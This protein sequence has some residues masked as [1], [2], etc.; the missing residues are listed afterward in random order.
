MVDETKIQIIPL[1]SQSTGDMIQ[2]I[3]RNDVPEGEQRVVVS[4]AKGQ[5]GHTIRDCD[6]SV[7][8]GLN[9]VFILNKKT[10]LPELVD[11]PLSRWD[12]IQRVGRVARDNERGIHL[13]LQPKDFRDVKSFVKECLDPGIRTEFIGRW[14]MKTLEKGENPYTTP[15][16]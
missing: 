16:P 6:V 3:C 7:D 5:V 13:L 12:L 10:N 8:S 15:Y 9:R 4:T 11:L 2:I 1:T 14:I